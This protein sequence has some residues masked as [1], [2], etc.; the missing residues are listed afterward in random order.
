MPCIPFFDK[1]GRMIGISCSRTINCYVCGKPHTALCDATRRNGTP[2]DNPMCDEHK[3]TV[4]EDTD[5]CS[6]HN[7]PHYIQQ[8]IENRKALG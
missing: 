1:E 7:K 4:G 6:Y 5:V 8:A 2:C 3:I